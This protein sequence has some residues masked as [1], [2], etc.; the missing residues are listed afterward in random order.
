MVSVRQMGYATFETPDLDRAAAYY[1]GFL[2]LAEIAREAGA[3]H[4]ACRQDVCSVVLR[5]GAA[6]RVAGLALQLAP[7]VDLNAVAAGLKATGV[8]ASLRTDAGPGQPVTLRIT[9]PAGMPVD[10][11]P[12]RTVAT[13][14][15]ADR[16]V[17]PRKL[18]HTAFYTPDIQARVRF[19]TEVLGFRVSDWIGDFFVFLRCNCDHHTVNFFRGPEHGLHHIAFELDD[20]N[21]VKAACDLLPGHGI[22][23]SWGPGRHGPGHN[24]FTYH[25]NPDGFSVEMFTELDQMSSEDNGWFDPRPWHKDRPQRPKVWD[26]AVDRT[27]NLWGPPRPEPPKR[28]G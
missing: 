18:G 17:L 15:S 19:Y 22:D 28:A 3:V 25:L 6:P 2:G 24:I 20:W 1:T 16:G 7:D 8:P 11:V 26:P 5:K 12:G 27:G 9:D 13:E 21:H 23:L 10:L 14:R 4:L